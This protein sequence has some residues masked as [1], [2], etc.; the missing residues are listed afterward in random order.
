MRLT[1]K[2]FPTYV[3][4]Y[5][6]TPEHGRT[7]ILVVFSYVVRI[8]DLCRNLEDILF[9]HFDL[10]SAVQRLCQSVPTGE[11]PGRLEAG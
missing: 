2:M 8:V 10:L 9:T 7:V 5:R 3:C 1:T 11:M 6:A 4:T